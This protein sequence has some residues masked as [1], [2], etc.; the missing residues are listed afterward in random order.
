MIPVTGDTCSNQ[1]HRDGQQRPGRRGLEREAT[2]LL[3][4]R[5]VSV[6]RDGRGGGRTV[7]MAAQP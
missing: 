2:E 6:S 4:G 5:R 1:I 7:G 3:S